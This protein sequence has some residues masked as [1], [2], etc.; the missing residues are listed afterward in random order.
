M[1]HRI[2]K[3]GGISAAGA[4]AVNGSAALLIGGRTASVK[5]WGLAS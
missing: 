2:A 3:T 5:A 1:G 4:E